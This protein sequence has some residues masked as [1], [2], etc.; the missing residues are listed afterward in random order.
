MEPDQTPKLG[1]IEEIR[2]D[3]KGKTTDERLHEDGSYLHK[4]GD[5]GDVTQTN[6]D[7]VD[8]KNQE[9]N[10][11]HPVD[12]DVKPDNKTTG[13]KGVLLKALDGGYGWVIVAACFFHHMVLGGF[14]R[15][16]GLFFLQYQERFNSGAQL[17]SW[18]S[19]LMSTINLFMGPLCGALVNRYSV[20]T[21]LIFATFLTSLGFILNGLAPNV[22]F[23]FFSQTIV[24]GIGRGLMSSVLLLN[25]YFDKHRSLAQGLSSAGVGFGA[26]AIVPLVQ[27]LFEEFGSLGT[28]MIIGAISL[29]GWVVAML[30]R[31]LSMHYRFL[32]ADRLKKRRLARSEGVPLTNITESQ[33]PVED[34]VNWDQLDELY[35]NPK[36]DDGP[37]IVSLQE[38]VEPFVVS[39]ESL[40]MAVSMPDIH[41]KPKK[42]NCLKESLAICFPV[43]HKRQGVATKHETF[44]WRL[45]KNIPFLIFCISNTF[46]LIA[47]KTAFTFLPAM[48]LSKGLSKQQAALVLT[49]T[50]ALDTFGRMAL[51][52]I[53]DIRV[54]RPFRPYIFNLLLFLIAGASFLVPSLNSFASFVVV[55]SVYG[56]LTGAFISQ[57]MV[58]LVDI[59]GRE[60]MASSLG[61]NK[62]FQGVGTLIGPPFAGALRDA[63]GTFDSAFY[64]GGACMLGSGVLLMFSNILLAIQKRRKAKTPN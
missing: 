23:L 59:L 30:F 26:F 46:F 40:N 19:S 22:Y 63:L 3:N 39:C 25:L 56:T 61:I 21:T 50:G 45:L 43:E 14:A 6:N 41:Y 49:I 37:D 55:S 54:C 4:N 42:E 51:G 13:D 8:G 35:L 12:S 1:T 16:E 58:V 36:Q 57:K 60:V 15:S 27:I 32:R 64:L 33:N 20:R 53:L 52:F 11:G 34:G 5:A 44:H 38:G 2:C 47:F 17:T 29:N 24:G 7:D 18:P 48:A 9:G 62:V 10:G 28:F 31:P